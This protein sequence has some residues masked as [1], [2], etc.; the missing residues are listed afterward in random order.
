VD[1]V[2]VGNTSLVVVGD[3]VVDSLA[4]M[5]KEVGDNM[6][7]EVGV[8]DRNFVGDIVDVVDVVD[9]EVAYY[10][11]VAG[12]VD[13]IGKIVMVAVVVAEGERN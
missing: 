8:V 13:E 7:V 3:A 6:V 2:V 11:I 12:E 9:D 1:I 4:E 5:D 10:S